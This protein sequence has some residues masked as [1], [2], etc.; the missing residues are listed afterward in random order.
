M[1]VNEIPLAKDIVMKEFF[2]KPGDGAEVSPEDLTFV[3]PQ[4][5]D[6]ERRVRL[7]HGEDLVKVGDVT[8]PTVYE[9][10]IPL[11]N[12]YLTAIEGR[13]FPRDPFRQVFEIRQKEKEAAVKFNGS[14]MSI[15]DWFCRSSPGIPDN[16][17]IEFT[18][19]Y[20]RFADF[21]ATDGSL[22]RSISGDEPN[23]G[24]TFDT[25]RDY[26]IQ[27]GREGRDLGL[28]NKLGA[29]FVA[30][31]KGRDG[32]DYAVLGRR[33]PKSDL[34]A[35]QICIIGGT[36]T[37]NDQLYEGGG[38]S[39][40]DHIRELGETEFE[41]E[42]LLNSA[43]INI[44]A[45][46]HSM[47]TFLRCRDPV[48]GVDV[49]PNI[50]VEDIAERCFGNKSAM[51]EHDRLYALPLTEDAVEALVNNNRGYFMDAGSATAVLLEARHADRVHAERVDKLIF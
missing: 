21:M 16:A 36:P 23:F 38:R 18:A 12:V 32:Q 3:H 28:V 10:T 20:A 5:E 34:V 29:A 47:K 48:Y 19:Q 8:L 17:F 45:R 26:S 4:K 9:G 11:D 51:E 27:H 22:D 33:N 37:W 43:E 40:A 13:W 1:H 41:E 25:L 7:Y 44:G 46:V 35:G 15:G 31:A 49:D 2:L 30:R 39:F 6:M 14:I 24:G 42:L 50:T